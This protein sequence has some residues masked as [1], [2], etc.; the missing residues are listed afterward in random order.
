MHQKVNKYSI[1]SENVSSGVSCENRSWL[2]CDKMENREDYLIFTLVCVRV[3]GVLIY[4]WVS[5]WL[6]GFWILK[7]TKKSAKLAHVFIVCSITLRISGCSHTRTK[8][9]FVLLL[10]FKTANV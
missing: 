5:E 9:G 8:Q 4:L 2:G 7:L 10:W 3:G 6:S 1:T